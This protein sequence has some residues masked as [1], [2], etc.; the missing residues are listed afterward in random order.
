MFGYVKMHIF[1]Q[2]RRGPQEKTD[3]R[4]QP[5]QCDEECQE[6]A[7]VLKLVLLLL[8]FCLLFQLPAIGQVTKTRQALV[9]NEVGARSQAIVPLVTSGILGNKKPSEIPTFVSTDYL[10]FD[11]EAADDSRSEDSVPVGSVLLNGWPGFWQAYKRHIFAGFVALLVETFLIVSLLL[12]RRKR[13]KSGA[14]LLRADAQ[15]RLAMESGKCVGWEWDLVRGEITWFGDLRTMFGITPETFVGKIGAFFDYVYPEDRK[16]VAE[17]V[18]DARQNHKPYSAEFRVVRIDSCT[19]WVRSQGTFEYATNG[20]AKR[21]FGVAIDITERKEA[22]QALKNSE[23]KFSKAFRQSPLA[24]TL[25]SAVDYRYIEVN[26]SFERMTGWSAE[27]V[28]G[29]TP[30]ELGAWIEP[31]QMKAFD[32]RLRAEGSVRNFEIQ[33]RRKDGAIRSVLKSCELI[34]I[35]GELSALFVTADITDQKQ[36]QQ[37]LRDSQNRLEGIVESAMDAIVAIDDEMR[38]VLFNA[39]AEKMFGTPAKDALGIRM[40]RFIPQ[41]FAAGHLTHVL[42]YGDTGVTNRAMGGLGTLWAV[43]ANGQE[44][45][46]EVSISQLEVGGR[47]LFTAI[48]RDVTERMKAEGVQRRFAAIVHSSE[49]A[50]L[51]MSLDGIIESWNPGA[52]RMY[53][54]SEAEAVG[55]S[56]MMIVPL[57]FQEEETEILRRMNRGEAIE[58]H[59]TVRLTKEGR[60]LVVSLS[61]SPIRDSAGKI[62]GISKI[63]RDITEQKHSEQSL[64]ESEERF[65][66]VANSAPVL[67]WMSGPDKLCTY[68]NET[69]LAFT[70]RSLQQELGNGWAEGV[71]PDDLAG[72]WKTY[73]TEFDKRARFQMEYRLR[74]HDGEYR[75]IFDQGVPRFNSDGSFAGYIGSC[76][77]ITERKVAQEALSGMSRKLIEAHEQERAWIARELHDG[78]N[79]EIALLA[80]NLDRLKQ[81]LSHLS[82]ANSQRLEDICARISALGSDIQALSHRLHSSKLEYLGLATAASSFCRE[83]SEKDHVQIDFRSGALPEKLPKEIGLCLFR[84]LQEALQN[85]TKHSGTQRFEVGL[86]NG[87]N[88][89]ELTVRDWGIGFDPVKAMEKPG[90]GLT[91]MN[92]RLKLVDGDLFIDSPRDGGTLVR[93]KVPLTISSRAAEA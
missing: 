8:L 82:P 80:V 91:S 2:C 6:A 83:L 42:R 15:R 48:V 51:S 75:W 59:E 55:H 41:R 25:R 58:H 22:E 17:A 30:L 68:F 73:E 69:W 90:L 89:I 45:P 67:I 9:S 13:K 28:L 56:I 50:I 72:C 10:L 5:G 27:E 26:E 32:E 53:G 36:I 4:L 70:G 93:A 87:S 40:E 92:E 7:P 34:E 37:S 81:G 18:A 1:G 21:M 11:W 24:V 60:R 31:A 61:Q 19:R 49:D 71:H 54:Y 46:I 12:E 29:R 44:F 52:Q 47:K 57:D 76:T 79:Q 35:K 78:I 66:R 38:I 3:Q 84:V 77:D 39:A 88:S 85:A 86:T 63:V 64:R 43:R 23:E 14:E 65:R 62:V 33:I 20:E 16:Q 74:R